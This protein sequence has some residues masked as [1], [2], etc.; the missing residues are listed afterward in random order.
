MS[1]TGGTTAALRLRFARTAW[2]PARYACP[3]FDPIGTRINL[4]LAAMNAPSPSDTPELDR[5]F[6]KTRC[7]R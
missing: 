2:S 4:A 7:G 3:M 5:L 1:E 6:A